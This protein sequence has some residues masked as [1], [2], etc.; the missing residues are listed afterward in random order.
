LDP[1]SVEAHISLGQ[2]LGNLGHLDQAIAEFSEALRLQPDSAE[3]R[4]N[5]QKA[6]EIKGRR[7]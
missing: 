1:D 2:T 7:R 3:A 6:L 4:T 5:L